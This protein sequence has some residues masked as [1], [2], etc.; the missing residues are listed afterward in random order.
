MPT[1]VP[2]PAQRPRSPSW[3]YSPASWPRSSHGPGGTVEQ[4]DAEETADRRPS[5]ARDVRADHA[6]PAEAGQLPRRR[7]QRGPRAVLA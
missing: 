5:S 7:V 6:S 1:D 3:S 2:R 4:A